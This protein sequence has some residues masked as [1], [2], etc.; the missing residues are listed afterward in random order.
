M[1]KIIKL[2]LVDDH[3][4]VIDGLEAAL[5]TYA[6]LQVVATANTAEA[7]IN[8]LQHQAVDVLLTDVMMPGTGGQQLA[9]EV[10]K[11]HPHIRI[12]ALSMSGNGSVVEEMI[13]DADIAGYLLK[14]STITELVQAIEK[15][16]SGGIYFQDGILAEL[17]RLSYCKREVENTRLTPREKQIIFLIEKDF[18]NK[19]IA[20]HLHIAVRTVETH[21][22]SICRKTG[23]SNSLA[24]VKWAY[25]HQLL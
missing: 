16:H 22:K 14:Q 2:A 18:S 4:I 6:S 21:R 19:Q 24:L 23:T 8:K 12:I 9:S 10:K 3:Q 13:N 5:K 11:L 7:M 15:V 20:E 17:T 1:R 25:D